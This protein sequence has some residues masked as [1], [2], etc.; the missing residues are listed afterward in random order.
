MTPVIT[1]SLYN[2]ILKA[3]LAIS[4]D[5]GAK[6]A[7]FTAAYPLIRA[8]VL[9]EAARACEFERVD[10]SETGDIGDAAYNMSCDDCAQA[11]RNMAK[12]G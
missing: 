8:A 6:V 7:L 4:V 5:D 3:T 10:A 2:D 12:E 9:E 11:I 1:G